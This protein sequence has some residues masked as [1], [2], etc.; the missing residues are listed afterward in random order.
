MQ[1]RQ[2]RALP[3]R[4]TYPLSNSYSSSFLCLL[5]ISL[6]YKRCMWCGPCP[7]HTC[8][9]RRPL[10]ARLALG[11]SSIYQQRTRHTMQSPRSSRNG[12]QR[13]R[14]MSKR[15]LSTCIVLGCI[16]GSTSDMSNRFVC[17]HVETDARRTHSRVRRFDLTRRTVCTRSNSRGVLPHST[18]SARR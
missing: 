2:P 12:P 18:R 10:S 1:Q 7:E 11:T 13:K 16:Q 15:P 6:R 14:G 9:G 4:F 5:R 17:M 3:S 8:L